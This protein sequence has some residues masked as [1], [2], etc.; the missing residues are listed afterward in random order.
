[1]TSPQIECVQAF[2][3]EPATRGGIFPVQPNGMTP[4]HATYYACA[5]HGELLDGALETWQVTTN[6]TDG[7]AA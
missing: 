5:G 7:G 3:R 1:M 2:C 4:T 6:S